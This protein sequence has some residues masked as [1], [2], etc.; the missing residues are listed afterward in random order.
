MV[1]SKNV[2]HARPINSTLLKR[3]TLHQPREK[4]QGR[5]IGA[6]DDYWNSPV[7][8]LGHPLRWIGDRILPT[9]ELPIGFFALFGGCRGG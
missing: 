3:T 2:E 9:D 4:S 1:T 7:D 5:R 8:E 6:H